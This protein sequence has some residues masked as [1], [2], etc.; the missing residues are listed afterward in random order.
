MNREALHMRHRHEKAAPDRNAV[1]LELL[2]RL[3]SIRCCTPSDWQAHTELQLLTLQR[4]NHRR[5]GKRLRAEQINGM[6][7]AQS[8]SSF[9]QG[10]SIRARARNQ[11]DR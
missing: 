9:S 6:S 3:W 10:R 11:T 4:T 2:R 1:V 8:L 5:L 7:V